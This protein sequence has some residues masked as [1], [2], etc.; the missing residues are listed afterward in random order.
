MGAGA[1]FFSLTCAVISIPEVFREPA[2]QDLF[3]SLTSRSAEKHII[4]AIVSD[5]ASCKDGHCGLPHTTTNPNDMSKKIVTQ[6]ST[7]ASRK[8]G[9]LSLV[10][11]AIAGHIPVNAKG[12]RL[13][14]YTKRPSTS[15]WQAYLQEIGNGDQPCRWFHLAKVCHFRDSC[16]HDHSAISAQ[17]LETLRYTIRRIPCDRGSHYRLIDCIYGHVCQEPDCITDDLKSCSMRRF[18]ALDLAFASWN[19]GRHAPEFPTG[20]PT[21]LPENDVEEASAESF[22]F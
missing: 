1:R 10:H 9:S 19:R 15:D 17:V 3:L 2:E 22:W 18:H 12:Q 20:G 4:T 7:N 5:K 14:Y 11:E 8:P 13:D 16:S 21:Q 6:L